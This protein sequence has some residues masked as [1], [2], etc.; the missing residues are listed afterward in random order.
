MASPS[1]DDLCLIYYPTFSVARSED[2]LT[3]D[4]PMLGGMHDLSLGLFGLTARRDANGHLFV[5]STPYPWSRRTLDVTTP[6]IYKYKERNPRDFPS[7]NAPDNATFPA[8]SSL[9]IHATINHIVARFMSR[10]ATRA[11]ALPDYIRHL[12]GAHISEVLRHGPVH[13]CDISAHIGVKARK[14]AAARSHS[15]F[16]LSDW[17]TNTS[18]TRVCTALT[19]AGLVLPPVCVD[20]FG[21][22]E[23]VVQQ[24][25]D[26]D[27]MY[28]DCE[29]VPESLRVPRETFR[30]RQSI[31][32]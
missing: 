26:A 32:E 17:P 14:Q 8:S 28:Y 11:W 27:F 20:K 4:A 25:E 29:S 30:D 19:I 21:V 12:E 13:V 1:H 16:S 9:R 23:E 24:V 7:L 10:S 3:G 18:T 2:A 5:R 15:M 31:S 22:R 6:F